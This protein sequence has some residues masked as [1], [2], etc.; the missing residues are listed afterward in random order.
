MSAVAPYPGCE[1]VTCGMQWA[2][3]RL[4]MVG[5]APS[6]RGSHDPRHALT[7][8]PMRRLFRASGIELMQYVRTFERHNL[9]P[10]WEGYRRVGE[11]DSGSRF[12]ARAAASS[13]RVLADRLA[14]G[15]R[16]VCWGTTVAAAFLGGREPP[17]PLEWREDEVEGL[18]NTYDVRLAII[19]HPSGLNRWWNT[20]E[21][22]AAAGA[23]VRA[24]VADVVAAREACGRTN[25]QGT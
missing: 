9:V 7:G 18:D 22:A 3:A 8:A 25:P 14:G 24:C 11:P 2:S 4:V 12:D 20:P 16:L 6:A 17:A 1:P 23:F 13:A 19:P 5:Q 21:N 10:G 15:R